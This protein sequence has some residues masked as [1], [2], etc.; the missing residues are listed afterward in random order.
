MSLMI[1]SLLQVRFS[2]I[3]LFKKIKSYSQDGVNFSVSLFS[4]SCE[5]LPFPL[6]AGL[7]KDIGVTKPT[8]LASE[9][10]G[11]QKSPQAA[12]MGGAAAGEDA[13][14]ASPSGFLELPK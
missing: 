14:L 13:E 1:C 2:Y 11:E 6:L 7:R 4:T 8:V 9:K 3:F 10:G 5:E 12:G